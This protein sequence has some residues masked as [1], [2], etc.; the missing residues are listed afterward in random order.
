MKKKHVLQLV[1]LPVIALLF[2]IF[3]IGCTNQP[4]NEQ[5]CDCSFCNERLYE[6]FLLERDFPN[7]VAYYDRT[8]EFTHDELLYA[9]NFIADYWEASPYCSIFNAIVELRLCV[10]RNRVVV[11]QYSD[12]EE[13]R[14]AFR[15]YVLDS[16]VIVL[17]DIRWGMPLSV[18]RRNLSRT[19]FFGVEANRSIGDLLYNGQQAQFTFA[20]LRDTM[21][22]VAD[23]MWADRLIGQYPEIRNAITTFH[24]CVISNRV[25]VRLR[26]YSEE[27][28]DAFRVIVTDSPAIS[29]MY[30][31][32]GT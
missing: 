29:F 32:R 5:R 16:P 15:T 26:N 21:A 12:S 10:P 30:F 2:A 31:R 24:L 1:L 23:F 18:P 4:S 27:I 3:G 13:L 19:I 28:K 9:F 22:L 25:I 6:S 11:V 20:E 7:F 8:I 17:E 14:V